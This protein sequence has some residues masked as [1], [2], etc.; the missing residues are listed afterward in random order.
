MK[1]RHD[2]SSIQLRL[3]SLQRGFSLAAPDRRDI[4]PHKS[5]SMR[6]KGILKSWNDERGFGF[7]APIQGGQ[8][9]FVHIKAFGARNGRPQANQLVF[10][11]MEIGPQGKTRAKNVEPVCA[12]RTYRRRGSPAPWGTATVFAI[13]AF[14]V[15]YGVISALWRPPPALAAIYAGVSLFTFLAYA[16][17]KSA[18]L[19]GAWRTSESTLHLLALGCGWPGALLA[20]QVL[21]HKST[22]TEFRS[23]FWATVVLNVVAF[24]ALTSPMGQ[25]LWATQ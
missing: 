14:V 5:A 25:A 21:R 20:Q 11:E 12:A 9:V 18:A 15:L 24:V 22:K 3:A 6:V 16:L 13:P 1:G 19:R 8:E 7:I 2:S 17:D 4:R 10:F 23:V